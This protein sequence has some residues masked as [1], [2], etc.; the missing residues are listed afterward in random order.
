MHVQSQRELEQLTRRLASLPRMYL[1]V[2]G[3]TRS[4]G[5]PEANRLLAEERAGAAESYLI[6]KGLNPN[7]V[8]AEAASPGGTGG[9]VQ[10][11][12][13]ELAQKPY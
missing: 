5:D 1:T 8:R 12:T 7:R 10:A 9:A 4:D 13:F 6:D 2:K 3:H 11:V